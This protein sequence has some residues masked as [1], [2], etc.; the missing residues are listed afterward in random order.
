MEQAASEKLLIAGMHLNQAGF[1]R[2]LRD[3]S[4]YRIDYAEK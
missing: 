3:G 1:A 4:G 2:I